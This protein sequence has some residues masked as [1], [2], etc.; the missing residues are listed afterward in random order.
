[1]GNWNGRKITCPDCGEATEHIKRTDVVSIVFLLA[2]AIW[3]TTTVTT[4]PACMRKRLLKNAAVNV[5]TAN[6]IWPLLILPATIYQVART[7][8]SGHDER[9]LSEIHSVQFNQELLQN[10]ASRMDD[11]RN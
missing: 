6:L 8:K 11:Y 7:Y 5:V 3:K 1:M 10:N 2:G 9:V 4:C